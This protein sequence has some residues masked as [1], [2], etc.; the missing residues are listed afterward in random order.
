MCSSRKSRKE[1]M[2][3]ET[4]KQVVYTY[5]RSKSLLSRRFGTICLIAFAGFLRIEEFLETKLANVRIFADHMIIIL[6]KSKTD[7]HRDGHEV[8]ISRTGS[9]YCPVSHVEDFLKDA[10][11]DLKKEKEAFLIPALHKTKKGHNASKHKGISY[12]RM[13]EMF[14]ENM[15]PL[16]LSVTAKIHAYLPDLFVL[17]C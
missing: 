4:V 9:P 6:P 14:N 8:T 2:P 16:L 12:S 15:K 13:R 11:L 3:L 1:P 10:K 5:C 17:M 7:Q